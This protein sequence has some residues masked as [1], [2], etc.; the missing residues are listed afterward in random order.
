MSECCSHIIRVYET[1]CL[2]LNVRMRNPHECL[3]VAA[4]RT[5]EEKKKTRNV[6]KKRR[7]SQTKVV[8]AQLEHERALSKQESDSIYKHVE[9]ILGE[10]AVGASTKERVHGT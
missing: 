10:V 3:N 1:M 7:R 9:V 5:L 8:E 6:Q 4:D 2:L